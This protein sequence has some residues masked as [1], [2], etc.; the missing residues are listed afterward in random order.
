MV[1]LWSNFQCQCHHDS[2]LLVSSGLDVGIRAQHKTIMQRVLGF[3]VRTRH[4]SVTRPVSP[5]DVSGRI[6]S[7]PSRLAS[8]RRS[9]CRPRPECIVDFYGDSSYFTSLYV[10]PMFGANNVKVIL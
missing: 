1:Y 9:P 7:G 2:E 10:N 8:I 6:T 3:C 4:Q 5:S